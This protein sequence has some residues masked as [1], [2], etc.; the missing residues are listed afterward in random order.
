M[1]LPSLRTVSMDLWAGR[2]LRHRDGAKGPASERSETGV[3]YLTTRT[4]KEIGLESTQPRE[5]KRLGPGAHRPGG[6][7]RRVQ[8]GKTGAGTQEP[9]PT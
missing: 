1:T 6:T 9:G 5:G 4:G 2:G 7:E 8:E 3:R